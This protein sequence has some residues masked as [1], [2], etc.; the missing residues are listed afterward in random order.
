MRSFMSRLTRVIIGSAAVLAIVALVLFLIGG[1]ERQ[2]RSR[3]EIAAPSD[4][5]FRYLT[6]LDTI[7]R[8]A[9]PGAFIRPLTE[10][11]HQEGSKLHVGFRLGSLP[12]E[13]DT[14]VLETIPDERLITAMQSSH[15]NARSDFQ[16][17]SS[18]GSTS[19]SHSF[20]IAP[21]GI[22]RIVAPFSG[23]QIQEK[24]DMGLNSL[25][26]IIENDFRRAEPH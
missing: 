15:W 12:M 7:R 3:V 6:D 5:V 1:R 23:G 9:S 20:R 10:G 4:V 21:R 13:V 11:G 14:E 24:L 25:G 18:D 19:L 8:W 17:E 22:W 2:Y 16:L 26:R